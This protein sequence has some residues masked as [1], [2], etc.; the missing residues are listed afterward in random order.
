MV[1]LFE[2]VGVIIVDCQCGSGQQVNY[3]IVGLIVV[4]VI[5][6]GIVCGI[7]VM[8]WVGLGVNVGLDCLLICVQLWDIDLLN[9]FEVVEWIVKWCGIICEDV[10]VFGFELQ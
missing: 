8:S 2:Y 3:L 7:E 4:G 10:D 9:Q 5:D 6:V 1:G